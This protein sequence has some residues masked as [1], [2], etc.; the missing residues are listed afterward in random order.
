MVKGGMLKR[1]Q[2]ILGFHV[3]VDDVLLVE[4]GNRCNYLSYVEPS[5]HRMEPAAP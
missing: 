3:T 2:H 1:Y 5:G 4:V